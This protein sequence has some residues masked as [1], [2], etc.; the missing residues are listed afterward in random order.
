MSSEPFP[1]PDVEDPRLVRFWDGAALG[2]LR[3]PRCT[4]CQ[5][6]NW[7]PEA[8]CRFC[9]AAEFA[10]GALSG[11]GTLFSWSHVLHPIEPSI[12]PLA[13]YTVAL[14]AIAE[15]PRVRLVSRLVDCDPQAL[16]ADMPVRTIFRDLGYPNLA[17]GVAAPLLV[18]DA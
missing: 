2:E 13:P 10:W 12:A 3:L 8:S 11:K 14:M 4:A 6:F 1:L 15:D 16:R 7:Y 9:S 18:P 5:R 17:T